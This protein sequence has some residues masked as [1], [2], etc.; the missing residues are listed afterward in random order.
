MDPGI[1]PTIPFERYADDIIVHCKSERQ[2]MIKGHISEETY[3]TIRADLLK[4][5]VDK[6]VSQAYI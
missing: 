4:D 3:L 5:K 2:A 1:C 6:D